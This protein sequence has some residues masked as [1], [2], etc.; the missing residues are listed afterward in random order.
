MKENGKII[1][2]GIVIA[3]GI[4]Y[5]LSDYFD[6]FKVLSFVSVILG[7][8]WLWLHDKG[9]FDNVEIKRLEGMLVESDAVISEH[10]EVLEDYENIFDGQVSEVPCVC[11]KNVFRGLFVPNVDNIIKCEECDSHYNV[12]VTLNPIL[13]S[14]PMDNEAAIEDLGKLHKELTDNIDN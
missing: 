14:E 12:Q 5:G 11:G 8:G 10:E 1:A 4:S 9:A 7:G 6:F 3:V 13:I 2:A